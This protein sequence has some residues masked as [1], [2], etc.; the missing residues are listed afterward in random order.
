MAK[1][2]IYDN[3]I[4]FEGYKKIRNNEINANTLFEM[5]ALFS[6]IPNLKNKRVLDMGCGFGDHCKQFVDA[7]A[8]KVIGIDISKKMLEVA[9]VENLD[10][11]ITYINMP[12]EEIEQLNEQFDIIISSL[13]FHYIE[14]FSGV[15]SKIYDLLSEDGR[16]IFS[17]ENPLCS[18]HSGGDR[19]TRDESGEKI[20]MNLSNYGI[21]GERESVWFVDNVKKY[22]RTFS[23]I[24]NT[25]IEAGFVIEKLIEPVPSDE[26]LERYPEYKDL[27]HKPDFLLVKAKKLVK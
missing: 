8:K 7:G 10:S 12:I 17:Q 13:A 20:Y 18:S 26:V 5:P 16:F 3:E 1:Q 6:M 27:L 9:K 4:F 15:V 11:R 14:D 25:L 2:N 24:L 23:T 19:W 22:H 21:E